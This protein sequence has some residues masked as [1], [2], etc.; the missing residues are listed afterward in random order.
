VHQRHC[1]E[2][3]CSRE[4]ANKMQVS[5][6]PRRIKIDLESRMSDEKRCDITVSY[7]NDND[8]LMV[9]IEAKGQWHKELFTAVSGQL[10]R[11]YTKHPDAKEFGIYLV[12]WFGANEKIAAKVQKE[13]TSAESLQESIEAKLTPEQREKI[14]VFVLDL[15]LNS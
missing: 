8:N 12:Y 15:E 3:D 5:L 14:S 6:Q 1:D 11:L 7:I 2:E 4:V 9:P 13:I 10:E